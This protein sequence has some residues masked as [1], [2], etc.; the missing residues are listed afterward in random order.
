MACAS[1]SLIDHSQEIFLKSILT[2]NLE[3]SWTTQP[4]LIRDLI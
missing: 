4:T 3:E 1:Q 2:E